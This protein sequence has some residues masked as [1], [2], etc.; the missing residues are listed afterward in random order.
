MDNMKDLS[1]DELIETYK[2]VDGY[3]ASLE[4]ELQKEPEPEA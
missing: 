2:I 1:F 3:L 4:E